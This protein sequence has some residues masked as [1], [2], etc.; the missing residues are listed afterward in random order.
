MP[1]GTD[2]KKIQGKTALSKQRIKNKTNNNNKRL[3]GRGENFL[4]QLH[5]KNIFS[6]PHYHHHSLFSYFLPFPLDVIRGQVETLGFYHHQ[7]IGGNALLL[8]LRWYQW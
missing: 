3:P 8:L 1:I 6:S 7:V 2:F 5:M 4:S